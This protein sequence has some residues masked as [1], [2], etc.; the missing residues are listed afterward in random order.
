[1]FKNFLLIFLISVT[2]IFAQTKA[3]LKN[4]D[5]K[6]LL[7]NHFIERVIS[8][9]PGSVGTTELVNKLSGKKYHVKDDVFGLHVVFSGLGPA[10]GEEQNGENDAL[11]TARD[12]K[13]VG[14]KSSD[15]VGGG[16]ELTLSFRF[17]WE[18]ARFYLDVNYEVFPAEFSM[19]KWIELADSSYGIQFLDRI[20]VESMKFESPDFSHGK[21]GQP[22]F[23]NDIFMGVEYPTVENKMDDG[24]LRIGYV[25][26]KKIVK[27]PFR[28]HTSII[29]AS[30]SPVKLRQTFM[31]YVD[32]IKVNGTRP[33]LLYNSW[34][35]LRN[36]A[37]A[38]DSAG[39][40]NEKTVLNAVS[41]FKRHLYD[42]YRIS[43]D[44]F[45]LDDA[46]DKYASLWNLDSTRF[47][48]G[49]T[50]VVDSLSTMSTSLG[51]WASPFGGYSNRDLRVNWAAAHGYE[52]TG[53]FYCLA[54]TKYKA[55]FTGKMDEYARDYHLGYFKWDGFLL[56]CNEPD[57]GHPTGIYSR[58][59]SVSSYIDVMQS[60]RKINPDIFLNITS[61][62][63][64]SP[65]WLRYADCI[66]MQGEDYGYQESL[67]SLNDRDK[68]ITYKDVV[69]WDDFRKS[70]LL[71]PI[72]SLMT[73]GIIKGRYNL[74]GG[75]NESLSSF[76][77]EVMMYFGRGVMMWELYI[78]PELLSH[79]EWNA[80]ASAIKWAKS[81]VDVLKHTRMILGNPSK[82][83][84]YGYVHMTKSKGIVVLRNP[85]VDR[86]TANVSLTAD[87]GDIDPNVPYYLK[88][89]YP[90]NYIFP[91]PVKLGE[92]LKLTLDGYEVL[93][94]ELIPAGA[95][96]GELP[97]G[98]R[99]S[100]E[101]GKL[102]VYGEAGTAAHVKA[103][104][105]KELGTIH[106]NGTAEAPKYKVIS[107]SSGV[108]GYSGHISIQVPSNYSN[109][110]LAMLV[111]SPRKIDGKFEIKVNG[112][113]RVPSVKKGNGQWYWAIVPL[114]KGG[115]DVECSI[116]MPGMGGANVSS[117]LMG[118]EALVQQQAGVSGRVDESNLPAKPYPCNEESKTIEISSYGV[119]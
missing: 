58:E 108:T 15:L 1:M 79:G 96:D 68:A 12:F 114:E 64:L 65:W 100:D 11:L 45:V 93:A 49:L 37:I 113:E 57:H 17:D 85:G 98:I 92:G 115:N 95:V 107:Q 67:P 97:V 76:S 36:P 38:H 43:L 63:W 16:K 61:G 71:F 112:V 110:R 74:L 99:Y 42:K 34:Y 39:V 21:F 55:A 73:H 40:M 52:T 69:L 103:L 59:A 25:V 75:A 56:S 89:I 70:D 82:G 30:R 86:K 44:G 2:S 5:G 88:V 3:Y 26:G 119:K 104:S 60:V 4:E 81:N 41:E 33:Y 78:T 10:P 111:T 35:D 46:W 105:G 80:L 31:D 54:G 91:H 19:R 84:V 48:N 13:Y 47:P 27:T 18:M 62:T 77:D 101:M 94:A 23:D 6:I 72:S 20:D 8:V 87:L 22:V 83:E 117:W 24:T 28:S 29:G 51:L 106:F 32:G 7:G 116:A 102:F 109:P 9:S 53:D 118:Q 50:P 90:Y 66:W 14:Y